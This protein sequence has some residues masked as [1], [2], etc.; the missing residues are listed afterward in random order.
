M[1][2][3]K[4]LTGFFDKVVLDNSLNPTHISLYISIFQFWNLNR[5]QNPISITRDEVMRISKICSKATYHK[6]MRE[7][8]DKGY[9]KYEP[10]YNPFRGSL[11]YLI[12]FSDDLKP[13]QKKDRK[14]LKNNQVLK[15]V[16]KLPSEQ[17]IEQEM[18]KHQTSNGTGTEQALVSSINS[19][20]NTNNINILNLKK[21]TQ[22]LKT[23]EL[24]LSKK[25]ENKKKVREK[26]DDVFNLSAPDCHLERVISSAVER[27]ETKEKIP[28]DWNDVLVFFKEKNNS[29]IEAEKFFNHFQSNGWLVGGKS[30]MKD[31]KA[32]A[33]N[34]ILNAQKFN[35]V[36]KQMQNSN[37]PTPGNLQTTIHKNYAEPL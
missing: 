4:H 31:W 11:V 25:E 33:R 22:N 13:V 21:Q 24:E 19:I 35:P 10:S 26:K 12:N 37:T 29:E 16:D 20:N 32:A 36:T 17:V 18:N 2:Y 30:K 15:Q 28:P 8:N 1:N 6:C 7:M 9:L 3:I 5:F 23:D 27:R 14:G 34:W